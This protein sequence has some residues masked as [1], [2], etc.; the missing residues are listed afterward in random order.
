MDAYIGLTFYIIRSY[1][2]ETPILEGKGGG[3]RGLHLLKKLKRSS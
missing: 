3:G 2:T 1:N